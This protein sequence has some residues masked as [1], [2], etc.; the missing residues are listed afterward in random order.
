M[1]ET[2]EHFLFTTT[3]HVLLGDTFFFFLLSTHASPLLVMP[4]KIGNWLKGVSKSNKKLILFRASVLCWSFCIAEMI[5][6][7]TKKFFSNTMQVIFM[8]FS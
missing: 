4:K 3:L 8:C 5:S 2:I 7:L 1:Q 6:F